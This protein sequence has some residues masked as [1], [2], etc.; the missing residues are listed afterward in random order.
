[1][2]IRWVATLSNGDKAV[3][4]SGEYQIVPGERKPWVRLTQFLVEKDLSLVSLELDVEGKKVSLPATDF[5]RFGLGD[6]N[7]IPLHYSLQYHIEGEFDQTGIFTQANYVD[8]VAHYQDFAVHYIQNLNGGDAYIT[9]TQG[10][11]PMAP[12][13]KVQ[14]PN[15]N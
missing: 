14:N 9:V 6:F 2:P 15:L 12:T 3:E 11:E 1:M 7:Y 5:N 10:F 4:Y 8:I 13:P